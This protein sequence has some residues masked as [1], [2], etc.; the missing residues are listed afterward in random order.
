MD[1]TAFNVLIHG[2]C[3]NQEIILAYIWFGKMI[4]RGFLPDVFTCNSFI[5]YLCKIRTF[6]EALKILGMMLKMGITSNCITYKMLV[7]GL[8]FT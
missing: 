5:G 7:Q 6:D 1:V 8:L 4:K 2:F 3:L